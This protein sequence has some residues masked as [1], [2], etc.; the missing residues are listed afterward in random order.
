MQ[1]GA[2][3]ARRH[4]GSTQFERFFKEPSFLGFLIMIS[5]Y[6]PQKGRLFGVKVGV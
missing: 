4:P 1:A 6:N 3:K 2:R 5:L